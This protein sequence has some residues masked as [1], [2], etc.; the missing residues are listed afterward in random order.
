M[1]TLIVIVNYRTAD[2]TVDCLHSIAPQIPT[3]PPTH[4]AICENDSGPDQAPI[5][6][7]LDE[8]K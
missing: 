6:I 4:I 3:L 5:F 8:L 2:L 7:H 1:S